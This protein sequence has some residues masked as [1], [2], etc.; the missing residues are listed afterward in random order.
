GGRRARGRPAAT[1]GPAAGGPAH[2]R[3]REGSSPGPSAGRCYKEEAPERKERAAVG[4]GRIGACYQRPVGGLE[5]TPVGLVE[6]GEER[7]EPRPLRPL[8]DGGLA[9]EHLEVFR[10]P[11]VEGGRPR[12]EQAVVEGR[13]TG[14]R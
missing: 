11:D 9:V 6:G 14:R 8:L 3:R 2:S 1:R 10:L 4:A 5:A 13:I 7:P 12:G